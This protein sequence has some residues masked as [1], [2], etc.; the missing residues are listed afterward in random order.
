[1]SYI[2]SNLVAGEHVIYQTRLHWIVML[3]H[4]LLGCL[5]FALPG[6]ILLYYA[7]TAH[8]MDTTLKHVTEIVG[9]PATKSQL[10]DSIANIEKITEDGKDVAANLK[11]ASEE[12]R[13]VVSDAKTL[14]AKMQGTVEHVDT[15][16]ASVSRDARDM[17]QRGSKFLDSVYNISN[18]V[19][20]G[21]GTLG[22]F[23]R[24]AKFYDALVFTTEKLGQAVEEFRV[25]IKEWQKGKIRVA[26]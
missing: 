2:E 26:F 5:L 13:T 7:F 14:V 25:L 21:E 23:V 12:A 1:M 11:S 19:E 15:E 24:D 10:K 16:V 3:G 6:A 20:R 9:D 18:S 22:R 4:I 8:S 17:M